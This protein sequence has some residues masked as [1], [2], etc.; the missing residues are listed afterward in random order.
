MILVCGIPSEPP[1]A[2][3]LDRLAS[4]PVEVVL[5]NQRAF[6]RTDLAFGVA[7]G[8]VCGT[9]TIDGRS[10]ALEGFEG[11]YVRLMD[12][13]LLP[14]LDGDLPDSA[15]RRRCRA[16]HDGLVR[17]LDVC[18]ARVVNRLGR[19][20]SNAS[21]PYQAQQIARYG[22]LVPETLITNDP[23]Q[24]LEF[25]ER[26]GRVIY[27]SISGVRSIVREVTAADLVR[28]DLVRACPTQ[29]QAY[30]EG[31]DV[32]V[33]TIGNRAFATRVTST[34]TD[35][36]YAASQGGDTTLDSADLPADLVERCLRLSASL[37]LDFAG[38]DLRLAP[39]ERVYCFEV[40]PS[41]AFSYYEAH[42]SQPI[43]ETLAR[44]LAGLPDAASAR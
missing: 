36:R 26:Y 31:V 8:R 44:Y 33:H 16:L 37:G 41:P 9:L 17:W 28:L 32:R 1:L 15:R 10:W 21:K 2:M 42:T 3:V 30:V 6:E 13:R 27:K 24:V 39:D 7:G 35:Y 20:G 18:P 5:F 22:F 38:I 43:A 11:V 29:F 12:D 14:E 4:L 19:M 23:E 34:A 40:N 25:V